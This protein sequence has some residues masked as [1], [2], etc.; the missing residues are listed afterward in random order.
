M[1]QQEIDFYNNKFIA[2]KIEIRKLR[3]KLRLTD[4][5]FTRLYCHNR[6]TELQGEQRFIYLLFAKYGL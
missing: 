5:K 2:C 1:R 6:I 4:D 3:K